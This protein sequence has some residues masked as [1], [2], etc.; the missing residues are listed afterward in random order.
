M[1]KG[2]THVDVDVN[3]LIRG[4]LSSTAVTVATGVTRTRVSVTPT[5]QEETG[6]EKP[7][8]KSLRLHTK[9]QAP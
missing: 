1:G 6:D 4:N 9:Y 5:L 3:A 2:K 7:Q 8:E